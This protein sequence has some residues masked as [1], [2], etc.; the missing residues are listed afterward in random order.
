MK[1]NWWWMFITKCS[2]PTPDLSSCTRYLYSMMKALRVIE[3]NQLA[4]AWLHLQNIFTVN[5]IPYGKAQASEQDL[6]QKFP[7]NIIEHLNS[8][9]KTYGEG[10]SLSFSCQHG[11]VECEVCN[12]A[13]G[14]TTCNRFV[15]FLENFQTASGPPTPPYF[16]KKMLSFCPGSRCP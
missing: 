12:C 7:A 2:A 4:P 9:L 8:L 6:S 1:G 10:S 13:L 15:E 16:R 3:I 14:V 5:F 11:R